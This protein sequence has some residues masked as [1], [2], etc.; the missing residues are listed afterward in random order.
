MIRVYSNGKLEQNYQTPAVAN[1]K[2][3]GDLTEMW[4]NV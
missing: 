1:I 4:F 3:T 2:G